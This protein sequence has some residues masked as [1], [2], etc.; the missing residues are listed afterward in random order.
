MAQKVW[1]LQSEKHRRDEKERSSENMPEFISNAQVCENLH[2]GMKTKWT[3][4]A[5]QVW[6]A[7]QKLQ[8]IH[9]DVAAR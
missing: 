9:M 7:N 2:N 8:P 4:K 6:R 5:N 3:F 1:S